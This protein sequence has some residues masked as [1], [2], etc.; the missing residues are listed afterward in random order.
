MTLGGCQPRA[1]S[2]S[3]TDKGRHFYAVV[4]ARLERE[5]HDELIDRR[6]TYH[7]I[8]AREVIG[9][10]RKSRAKSGGEWP[11]RSGP[12]H[13][14]P[15]ERQRPGRASRNGSWSSEVED[16]IEPKLTAR[17][18]ASDQSPPEPARAGDDAGV[19]AARLRQ[20]LRAGEVERWI[21]PVAGGRRDDHAARGARPVSNETLPAIGEQVREALLGARPDGLTMAALAA[22]VVGPRSAPEVEDAVRRLWHTGELAR[23]RDGTFALTPQGRSGRR[24]ESDR[25]MDEAVRRLAERV[26]RDGHASTGCGSGRSTP[27]CSA[28]GAPAAASWS[29]R[30][31][32]GRCVHLRHPDRRQPRGT[33]ANAA[34][35]AT[36]AGRCTRATRGGGRSAPAAADPKGLQAHTCRECRKRRPGGYNRGRRGGGSRPILISEEL[37]AE[38][39]RLYAG[40][41]EPPSGRGRVS[42]AHR[43]QDRRLVRGG[44]V[45]PLQAPG[46]EAPPAA[47]GDRRAQ[48]QARPQGA[49][50]D[51][52]AAERLPPVAGRT[53]RLAGDPGAGAAAVQGRE[54]PPARQGQALPAPR[55]RRLAR[56]ADPHD[57]RRALERQ[58]AT[59][60]M[61]ARVGSDATPALARAA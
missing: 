10:W 51:A 59:A 58:A 44:V 46:L 43:I 30:G 25:A 34:T 52:R 9:I 13:D 14:R 56:T 39:R 18:G 3:P 12:R 60:R 53:A 21:A 57:P 29:P 8:K 36:P 7:R 11:K 55:A 37:L 20:Q 22:Q 5:L 31:W 61:R 48:P 19:A 4:I 50:A 6:V 45:R 32:D 27:R 42:S 2:C 49:P 47:R 1:T 28:D 16:A 41:L 26:R 40:G 23:R 54:A 38:A 35:T 33:R 17:T 15:P 24:C